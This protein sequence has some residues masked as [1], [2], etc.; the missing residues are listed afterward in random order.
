MAIDFLKESSISDADY[1]KQVLA[2]ADELIVSV[3]WRFDEQQ[4]DGFHHN[5]SSHEFFRRLR[6]LINK[7]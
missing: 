2:D 5:F 6:R 4:A 7:T 3:R 1:F